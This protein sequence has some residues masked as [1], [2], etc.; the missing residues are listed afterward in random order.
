MNLVQYRDA[1]DCDYTYFWTYVDDSGV[2]KVVNG[3]FSTKEQAQEWYEQ[4]VRKIESF[5]K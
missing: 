3:V 4:Q 2:E 1:H 5:K